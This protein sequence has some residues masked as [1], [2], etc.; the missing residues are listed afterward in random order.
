L[1]VY[2]N[3]FHRRQ[4]NHQPAIDGR[5]P[6]HVVTATTNSHLEAQ[7]ARE[8]DGIDHVGHATTSGDQRRTFVYQAVV[9]FSRFLVAGVRGLQELSRERVGKLCRSVGNGW[10]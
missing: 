2:V 9:D 10:N 7:L 3:A 5:A 6:C 8:A 4:V 1:G